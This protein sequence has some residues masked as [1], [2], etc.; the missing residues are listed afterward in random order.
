MTAGAVPAAFSADWLQQREPFDRAA[1]DA[2]AARLRLPAWL[3]SIRPAQGP[4]RVI[5][6]GCGTGAN[7][8]WLA[9]RLIQAQQWLLVDQ[10]PVLLARLHTGAA[11]V[12]QLT[13]P[14]DL[15]HDLE[16][17]P[18]ADCTLVTCSAL[19]D[20]VGEPWLQRLV[21]TCAVARVPVLWA[22]SVDG[23]QAW[24]PADPADGLAQRLFAAHQRRDKGFGPALGAHAPAVAARALRAA[25]YRVCSARSDWRIDARGDAAAAALQRA[26]IDGI[27]AAA[28]EQ[29]PRDAAALNDW[30]VRRQ[31]LAAHSRLTIGHIDL[32]AAPR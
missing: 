14:L 28:I 23:R 12:E 25:G 29:S 6:L 17:L 27:A 7:L 9:P 3:A 4:W 21:R 5:D 8:R 15:A 1:R 18:A 2:A 31:A 19:L 32:A 16:T 20:L 11:Q 26:L 13:L 10:D 24:T 30:R 22:L